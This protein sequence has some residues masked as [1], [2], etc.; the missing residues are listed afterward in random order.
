MS[1]GRV[2]LV[3]PP[4]L[5]TDALVAALYPQPL[6]LVSIG[7]VLQG[8]GYDVGLMDFSLPAQSSSVPAPPSFDNL[9][10]HPPYRLYGTPLSEVDECLRQVAG[11]YD[12]VGL[13][14][15][16]CNIALGGGV[17]VARIVREL[18]LPLVV[19][20]PFATTAPDEALAR[21]AP[22][23]LVV[24]EGE[25]VAAEAFSSALAGADG[26]VVRGDPMP[27]D[28]VPLP[29][30][31]L[32]PP[33]D[34]PRVGS[35]IRGVLQISR[36]CPHACS[37]CSVHTVQG[38][39]HRRLTGPAITRHLRNLADHG[40]TYFCFLDDNLFINTEATDEVLS[41][42]RALRR[43]VPNARFYVEEGIEVRMAARV[44][45]LASI[46]RAGFDNVG[47]GLETMN[48]E[49]RA[50]V[51]KP[52]N[53]RHLRDAV[54]QAE[55]AGLTARAFYIIGLPGD[56]LASVAEDVVRFGSLG[57]A[58]RP[59]NLKLYPGTDVQRQYLAAGLIGPDYDW[60]LSS[61]HTPDQPGLTFRQI[62]RL[63]A[64][65]GAIGHFAEEYGV[66]LCADT[67]EDIQAKLAQ[68]GLTLERDCGELTL[69]A[70]HAYYRATPYRHALGLL[71]LRE[72]APGYDVVQPAP[73]LLVARPNLLGGDEV[74][75]ALAE[76]LHRSTYPTL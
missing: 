45:L 27:M 42:C 51:G 70:A 19:G 41:A 64:V 22:N 6:G 25:A 1:K 34:Y 3:V 59:N 31:S 74:Q 55:D 11:L 13:Y 18:G 24:G 50:A 71:L 72:G 16:Q 39:H 2:L 69:R 66:R 32:A 15:G 30:W 60:R 47:L 46:K 56:T 36:G 65:L 62:R 68:H 7:T 5:T 53:A 54:T 48:N 44:G 33:A 20:G 49:R 29:D 35:R 63:R 38:R 9:G 10:G 43:D 57:L 67:F 73:D 4:Y 14:G 40:V 28:E 37:F 12:V 17:E 23:V 61:W 26:L 76:A 52:Y 75:D 8:A 58:A 21:F